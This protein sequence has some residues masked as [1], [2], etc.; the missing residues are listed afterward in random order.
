MK[1]MVL[2]GYGKADKV[3][4]CREMPEPNML[5]HQVK[6]K[7]KAFGLNYADVMA[8]LGLYNECPKPPVV[9]GYDVVGEI[10]AVGKEVKNWHIGQQAIALTRFGGYAEYVVA[11]QRAIAEVPANID[12]AAATGLA[13]QYTTA[14]YATHELVNIFPGDVVL[15]HAAAGG[16]GS[17]ILQMCLLKGATV[18]ATAGSDEKINWLKS[19][20]ATYTVNYRKQDY[21]E[22]IKKWGPHQKVDIVFD[23]IAGSNIGKGF[24]M[25]NAGGRL[26]M[27]GVSKLSESTNPL[28]VL[29]NAL[30]FGIYHPAEFMMSSKSILAVN[31]LNIADHKPEII[32][33]CMQASVAYYASGKIDVPH[34]KVVPLSALAEMHA[35]L[36]NRSTMGKIAVMWNE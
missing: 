18:I 12:S 5:D 7:V 10:E 23:S 14:Y 33:R 11:D 19:M 6:I 24:K 13:T 1:A 3:F 16:V 22:E 32:Q 34:T 36:E 2:T 30:S 31:M 25:L 9:L 20:G 15:V 17:G 4:E 27:Y 29:K 26:V 28:I 21:V 35:A 8:R